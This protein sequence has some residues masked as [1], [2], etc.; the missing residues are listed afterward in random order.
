M[1]FYAKHKISL[2]ENF[3]YKNIVQKFFIIFFVFLFEIDFTVNFLAYS[4]F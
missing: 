4:A 2:Q 3:N 1:F